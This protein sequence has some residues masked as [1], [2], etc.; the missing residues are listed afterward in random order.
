[1]MGSRGLPPKMFF[2]ATPSRTSENA[3][4]EHGMKAAFA[5]DICFQS[6]N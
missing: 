2:E 4:L 6:E 1:M 3:L 5:I